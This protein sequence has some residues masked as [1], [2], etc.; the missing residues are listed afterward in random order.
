VLKLVRRLL[1]LA[2]VVFV[3]GMVGLAITAQAAPLAG[4][5]LYAVRSASMTPALEVGSLVIAQ[6]VDPAVVQTGD[7]ITVKARTGATVTHRVVTV[8]PNDAG[9]VFST[10]GDANASPDP[11][12]T[13]ADQLQGRVAGQVPLLGFLLAMLAMPS[14][15]V[16][17]LSIGAALATAVWLVDDL[18]ADAEAEAEHEEELEELDRRAR[19]LG[20]GQAVLR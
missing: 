19:G 6:H 8:T 10:R 3:V 1:E 12:A 9:P 16:A 4:Y 11:V 18:E 5:G 17:V 13:R 20:G 2:L 14:G 15:V 7:V